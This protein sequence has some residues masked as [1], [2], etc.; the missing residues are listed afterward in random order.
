[1]LVL[2]GL[3]QRNDVTTAGV[4]IAWLPKGLASR[5]PVGIS[6]SCRCVKL[7][8]RM[9]AVLKAAQEDME[10]QLSGHATAAKCRMPLPSLLPCVQLLCSPA[11]C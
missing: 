6:T 11:P 4:D 8:L 7:D 9:N 5:S 1:M 3:E 2:G 10:P